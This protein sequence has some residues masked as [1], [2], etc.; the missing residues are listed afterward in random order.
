MSLVSQ[1]STSY[2][3]PT[4]KLQ[5]PTTDAKPTVSNSKHAGKAD[6]IFSRAHSAYQPIAAQS[7]EHVAMQ[8]M[9]LKEAAGNLVQRM[10]SA[11]SNYHEFQFNGQKALLMR[12]A[13]ATNYHLSIRNAHASS[14]I[15]SRVFHPS[16]PLQFEINPYTCDVRQTSGHPLNIGEMTAALH[17]ANMNL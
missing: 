17:V 5:A 14:S 8:Q 2:K 7:P 9:Q 13:G 12:Q 15:L 6:G 11:N 3:A 1:A 10:M 4:Q 16:K